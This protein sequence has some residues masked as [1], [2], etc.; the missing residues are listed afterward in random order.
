LVV[1]DDKDIVETIKGNLGLDGY[2]VL[3]AFDGRSGVDM[4]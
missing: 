1:D 2:E 3:S 4:A